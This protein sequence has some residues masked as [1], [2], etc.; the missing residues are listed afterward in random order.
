M[1]Y[2]AVFIACFQAHQSE[3][4]STLLIRPD[5][6]AQEDAR[7]S[8]DDGAQAKVRNRSDSDPL[9]DK[10]PVLRF[11]NVDV[12]DSTPIPDRRSK[13]LDFDELDQLIKDLE[14]S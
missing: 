5:I 9:L 12:K 4:A 7:G 14:Q 1:V 8:Q 11:H 3:E 6:L 13:G 2:C 10:Y